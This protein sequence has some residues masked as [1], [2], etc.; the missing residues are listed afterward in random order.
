MLGHRL[1]GVTAGYVLKRLDKPLIASADRVSVHL[2]HVM[3]G[4]S[5]GGNVLPFEAAA[6]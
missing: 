1:A 6:G 4:V 3:R 5:V 2:D